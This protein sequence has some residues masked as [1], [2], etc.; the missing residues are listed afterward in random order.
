MSSKLKLLL[1]SGGGFAV[2]AFCQNHLL[3]FDRKESV[4]QHGKKPGLP[5]FGTVSAASAAIMSPA[6][7]EPAVP[8]VPEKKM[9]LIPPEPPKGLS[10]VSEIMRFGFPGFDNI[11]SR[12]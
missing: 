7:S 12:R 9:D 1:A 2:G 6:L 3:S 11:R 4:F 8:I 10:R 5:I